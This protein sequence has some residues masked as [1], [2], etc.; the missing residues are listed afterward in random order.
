MSLATRAELEH[1][2]EL[3]YSVMQPTP[4]HCSPLLSKSCGTEVWVKHETSTP[5][6]SAI[7]TPRASP[8]RAGGFDVGRD[9]CECPHRGHRYPSGQREAVR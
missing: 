7:P 3:V 6:S 1:A 5:S 8:P 9:G 4:Q 2:A